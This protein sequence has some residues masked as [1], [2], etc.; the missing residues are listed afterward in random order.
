MDLLSIV[1]TTTNFVLCHLK[2]DGL[3]AAKLVSECRK[4]GVYLRDVGNLGKQFGKHTIRI[5]IKDSQTNQ[6]ILQTL[7]SVLISSSVNHS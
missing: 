1:N 5:A 2:E 7:S 4:V 6:R 3:T